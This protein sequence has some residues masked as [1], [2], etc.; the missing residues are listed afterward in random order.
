MWQRVTAKTSGSAR[1]GK[2]EKYAC[3]MAASSFSYP[4]SA[5]K[6]IAA[7]RIS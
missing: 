7:P 5:M 6:I 4:L 1:I 3:S 2:I